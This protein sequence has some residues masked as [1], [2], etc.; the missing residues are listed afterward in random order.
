MGDIIDITEQLR[1]RKWPTE[2]EAQYVLRHI[3]TSELTLVI[4]DGVSKLLEVIAS[5]Q[6]EEQLPVFS[7][8]RLS[9]CVLEFIKEVNDEIYPAKRID[10]KQRIKI[11]IAEAMCRDIEI[12]FAEL[13][14]KMQTYQP[15]EV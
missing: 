3:R 15:D 1:N 8:N 10:D 14:Q 4:S 13:K 11:F 2:V 9:R 7:L 6:L 5:S 12:L